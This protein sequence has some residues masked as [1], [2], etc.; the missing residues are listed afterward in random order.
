M[1][2]IYVRLRDE[3]GVKD[4]DVAK[5]TGITKSTFTDWKKGRSVPKDEKIQKIADY[6]GVSAYYLRTG[7]TREIVIDAKPFRALADRADEELA[8]GLSQVRK[9]Y[10]L[11][12]ENDRN[13]ILTLMRAKLSKYFDEEKETSDE[14]KSVG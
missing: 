1:Y 14:S 13:E 9:M 3:K 4:S 7:K 12:D 5:A 10:V 11:F 2:D 8:P 6:F